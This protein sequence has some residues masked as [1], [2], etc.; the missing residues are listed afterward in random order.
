MK[1][2]LPPDEQCGVRLKEKAHKEWEFVE[3]GFCQQ[4]SGRGC[5]NAFGDVRE[6]LRKEEGRRRGAVK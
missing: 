1:H 5:A 6:A 4:Q 3:A 2:Y